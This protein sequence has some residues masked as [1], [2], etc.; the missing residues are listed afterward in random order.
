V[1]FLIG[2]IETIGQRILPTAADAAAGAT[3][4]VLAVPTP[5]DRDRA[6]QPEKAPGIALSG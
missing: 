6:S 2:A 3:P 1:L 4:V 5:G